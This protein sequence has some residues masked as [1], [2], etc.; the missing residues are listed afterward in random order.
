M[1]ANEALRD[2]QYR[3]SPIVGGH[4]TFVFNRGGVFILETLIIFKIRKKMP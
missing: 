4:T 1:L 2:V 3:P